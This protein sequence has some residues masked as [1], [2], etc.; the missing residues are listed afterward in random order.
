MVGDSEVGMWRDMGVGR[1]VRANLER[2]RSR[3]WVNERAR[4]VLGGDV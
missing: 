2:I 4:A 1:N 3:A